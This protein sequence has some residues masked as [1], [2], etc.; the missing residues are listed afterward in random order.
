MKKLLVAVL[1]ACMM[2]IS[3]GAAWADSIDLSGYTNE[4]IIELQDKV[5]A[6]VLNRHIEKTAALPVGTYVAGKDIPVGSYIYTVTVLNIEEYGD[7]FQ[8]GIVYVRTPEDPEDEY[9]SK[10]YECVEN[11]T[12]ASYY[13]T[14]DEGDKLVSPVA[15]TLTISSGVMFK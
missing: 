12:A 13:I 15:F 4:E 8:F 11:T 1:A 10:L 5:Q 6:E 2:I 14:L 9:P 7:G 3:V